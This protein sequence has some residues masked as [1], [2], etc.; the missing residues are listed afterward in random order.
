MKQ[1][2]ETHS[3]VLPAI[4]LNYHG[5]SVVQRRIADYVLTHSAD[6]MYLTITDLAEA[7]DTSET[8]IMRF[9]RKI[10]FTSFQ[11]FRVRIAQEGQTE[12]PR[13]AFS[14]IGR[15]DTTSDVRDKVLASTVTAIEDLKRLV[16][17]KAIDEAVGAIL[18][19]DKVMLFGVGSSAYIAGDLYH[20]LIRL[21]INAVTSH[22]PHIMAIHCANASERDLVVCVSHSGESQAILECTELA[23]PR[24][25]AVICLTSYPN[26]SVAKRSDVR[27]LSSA[28]ETT[29][30]PDAMT[31]RILQMVIIDF[32]T[33]ALTLQL[34]PV[35]IESIGRSQVAVARQKT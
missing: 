27:L 13:Y 18:Q 8:T 3:E 16:P 12:N 33:I 10:G 19:A 17:E 34:E 1:N 21:G 31:S 5:L 4:R 2:D 35:S 15:E 28:T 7:C 22:D 25:A 29:F 23:K 20:K 14:D 26:S 9:L 6:V 30:R 11:V 24:G 32:L